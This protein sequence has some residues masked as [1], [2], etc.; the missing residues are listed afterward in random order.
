[1]HIGGFAGGPGDNAIRPERDMV[2]PAVFRVACQDTACALGVSGDDFAIVA[3]GDDAA[4]VGHR[5]EDRPAMGADPARLAVGR[6]KDDRFFAE[7]E[8]GGAAK[9]M[10]ADDAAVDRDR[11]GAFDDRN[12]VAAACGHLSTPSLRPGRGAMAPRQ[13]LGSC[14]A[15]EA[16]RRVA[17]F[18][19]AALEPLG[20]HF[21]GQVAANENDAAVARLAGFPWPLMITVENHV[22]ALEDKALV[23]VF[24]RENAFAAQ[25]VRAFL[26]HQVLHPGEEFV[27][28]ERLV[29]VQCN[30]LHLLIVVV[31]EPAMRMRMRVIMIVVVV[32]IMIMMMVMIVVVA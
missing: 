7:N 25:N 9:K 30:R 13:P 17:L 15:S 24:E 2:D 29:G 8:S 31:L 5:C 18:G 12:C 14:A 20:D 19:D 10:R 11:P 22:H 3:G 16:L 21:A 32:V 4:V 28:I 6:R 23:V 26:L 1:M 27:G